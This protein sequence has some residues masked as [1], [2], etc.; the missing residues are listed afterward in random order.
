MKLFEISSNIG[1][2]NIYVSFY[3]ALN[4]CEEVETLL[5][6]IGLSKAENC[7]LKYVKTGV[8]KL[9]ARAFTPFSIEISAI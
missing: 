7:M 3:V 5:N 6:K 1:H 2:T 4:G 9:N 8:N